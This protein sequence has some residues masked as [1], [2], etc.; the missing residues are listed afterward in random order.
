MVSS[1]WPRGRSVTSTIPVE[2]EQKEKQP[3]RARSKSAKGRKSGTGSTTV[4]AAV[5]PPATRPR[6]SSRK[7]ASSTVSNAALEAPVAAVA[8]MQEGK[9]VVGNG[10]TIW[11]LY[12]SL[13][14]VFCRY[15]QQLR[16]HAFHLETLPAPAMEL[17]WQWLVATS[18]KSTTSVVRLLQGVSA[19]SALCVGIGYYTFK[20]CFRV[21]QGSMA[22][23]L[24]GQLPQKLKAI[25][26]F[27]CFYVLDFLVHV[28]TVCVITYFWWRHVDSISAVVAWVYHR[29][30]SFVHS[31]GATL[32]FTRVEEVYGFRE[33][34]PWWSYM[35]MYASEFLIISFALFTASQKVMGRA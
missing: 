24:Y 9:K 31:K 6:A 15:E 7:R 3:K 18:P 33:P 30:W 32:F 23:Q 4:D 17:L 26:P 1:P 5:P 8:E 21:V 25:I 22:S 12:L 35:A 28:I 29:L 10:M 14:T 19:V 20:V 13:L 16:M 2:W 27:W 11:W 34:M